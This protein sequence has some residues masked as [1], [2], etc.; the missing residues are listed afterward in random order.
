MRRILFCIAAGL[1]L[2]GCGLNR[3]DGYTREDLQNIA[4]LELYEAEN[5][6]LLKTIE[7]E[8]TLYEYI[9]ATQFSEDV[10]DTY[11]TETEKELEETAEN[12]GASYYLLVYT[13]PAARLGDQEPEENY[14]TV[15]YQDTDIVK[16]VV[17]DAAIKNVT[18]PEDMRTFYYKMSEEESAF[19]R[20]L[21]AGD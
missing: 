18:L 4:R 14:R 3:E 1:L 7:D 20:G 9:Q 19:Y 10:F 21:L 17:A 11:E 16:D 12:A 2:T 15:L 6:E 5:D 8:E 13:Y